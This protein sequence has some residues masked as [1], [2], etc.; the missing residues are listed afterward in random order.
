MNSDK[1]LREQK[2]M[3]LATVNSNGVPHVVPVWYLYDGKKFQIGTNTKTVK[4]R[5]V[6]AN[7]LVAYCIDKGVRSP[8]IMCHTGRG[9]AKIITGSEV[10]KIAESILL[11]YFDSMESKRAQELLDD[12]DCIIEI[13]PSNSCEWS[14]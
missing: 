9:I 6:S 3:R 4:A 12:T 10:A 8:D 2:I 7:K 11:L 14:Y 1:F 5:N 13:T